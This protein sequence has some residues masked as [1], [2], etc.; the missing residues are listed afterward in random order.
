MSGGDQTGG[1]PGPGGSKDVNVRAHAQRGGAWPCSLL[2]SA[3][4]ALGCAG[5][6]YL[7]HL[8][9]PGEVI[10]LPLQVCARV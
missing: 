6:L 8:Q 5:F 1:S 2:D 10:H 4:L 7:L 3:A 9:V